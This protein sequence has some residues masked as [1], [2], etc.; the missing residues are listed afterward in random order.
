M[1]EAFSFL[2]ATAWAE[3]FND[4]FTAIVGENTSVWMRLIH[5]LVFTLI[6]VVV[7]IMFDNDEEDH[8]D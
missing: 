4:M 8:E 6:A 3:L 7:T 5:A 2:V 1:R